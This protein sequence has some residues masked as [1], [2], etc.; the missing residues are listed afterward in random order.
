MDP[1]FSLAFLHRQVDTESAV[2]TL[3]NVLSVLPGNQ[4]VARGTRRDTARPL[5]CGD[6]DETV[7]VGY[8]GNLAID[9]YLGPL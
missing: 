3:D 2:R 9:Q 8:S 1:C 6:E 7:F 4:F 5:A